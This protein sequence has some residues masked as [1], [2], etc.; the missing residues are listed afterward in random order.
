MAGAERDLDAAAADVDDDG[1]VA[2][3]VDAVD[4]GQVDEPRFFGAGD[5]ADADAGLRDRPR[6]G[7]RRRSRLRA[8]ALVA[9]AMISSTSCDSAS[10]RNFDSACS[11][12]CIAVG[13]SARP[14]R[15]PAPSRTMSFSRSMTSNDRSGRTCTT[16]MWIELVPMSMA[17][18][19]MREAGSGLAGPACAR[20]MAV[21]YWRGRSTFQD[22]PKPS[23][24][25][26][27]EPSRRPRRDPRCS[28][29]APRALKRH[30]PAAIDGD[31]IGVHQ[32][33]VASRRLREAVP[34]LADGRQGHEGAAR[35]GGKIRRLTQALG[36]VRELDVTL[37]LLDELARATDAAASRARSSPRAA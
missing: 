15:P 32:A 28:S 14:S 8:T 35:P 27:H 25:S 31:D 18:M 5:D 22:A 11:A 4:R 19:R 24:Q 29:A 1:R 30:L 6:R 23:R 12:A 9:A 20:Y 13:V 21:I 17:A 26:Y 36:T 3:D 7:T 10:R 33:R 34:V 2:A 16:I 37:Q